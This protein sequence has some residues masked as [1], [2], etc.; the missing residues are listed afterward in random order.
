LVIGEE[1]VLKG[2]R[3]VD[4]VLREVAEAGEFPGCEF[5]W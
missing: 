2:A 5:L 3:I 4:Q 1:D